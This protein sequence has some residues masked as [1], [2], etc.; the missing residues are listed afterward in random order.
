MNQQEPPVMSLPKA[1]QSDLSDL[2]ISD[3]SNDTPTNQR[4]DRHCHRDRAAVTTSGGA[5]RPFFAPWQVA[6]DWSADH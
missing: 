2:T 5:L 1:A 6:P 4:S 3:Q